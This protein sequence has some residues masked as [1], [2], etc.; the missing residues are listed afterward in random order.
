MDVVSTLKQL[1]AEIIMRM[2]RG[3]A[4]SFVDWRRQ[5]REAFARIDLLAAETPAPAHA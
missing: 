4:W 5:R 2:R 1:Q 3:D